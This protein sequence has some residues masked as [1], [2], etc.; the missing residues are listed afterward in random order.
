MISQARLKRGASIATTTG[1]ANRLQAYGR[2]HAQS[3]FSSLGRLLGTPFSS[4]AAILV[5]AVALSLPAVF[6]VLVDNIRLVSGQFVDSNQITL[7]LKPE[8]TDLNAARVADRLLK[9]PEIVSVKLITKDQALEEFKEYSGFS[10]AIEILDYNPLPATIQVNP[11][12]TLVPDDLEKLGRE[13]EAI[14]EADFAQFDLQWVKRLQA[15][16][17]L[18]QRAVEIISVL[19]GAGVVFVVGNTIRL[20]LRTR[21]DE[22]VVSKLL[23]ATNAFIRRPFLYSGFWYGLG[24]G[25]IAAILVTG[26]L[27]YFEGPIR[28]LSVL[29]ESNFQLAYLGFTRVIAL[30][31]ISCLLGIAGAWM[32][33]LQQ[34][35]KIN[36]D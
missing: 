14:P 15:I 7:F 31:A 22:I 30:L 27:F 12:T 16:V 19:L 18:A 29:Y 33:L 26:V 28:Q 17:E 6:Y 9:I 34:L 36:P 5:V 25:L 3:F 20:E 23:G 21:Q 2:S 11:Q 10:A 32:V 4:L 24:G 8:I 35:Q 1:L 13:I